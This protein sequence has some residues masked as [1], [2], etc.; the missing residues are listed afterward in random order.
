MLDK[1]I[2]VKH[3]NG[4]SSTT[5]VQTGCYSRY[6]GQLDLADLTS[7]VNTKRSLLSSPSVTEKITADTDIKE[8]VATMVKPLLHLRH[9][10]VGF[11]TEDSRQQSK[12]LGLCHR[13]PC[14]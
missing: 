8:Y 14:S 7:R 9:E 6:V 12:A 4:N 3:D 11:A 13:Q 1:R 2:I 10:I 5:I